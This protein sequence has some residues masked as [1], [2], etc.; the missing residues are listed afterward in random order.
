MVRRSCTAISAGKPGYRNQGRLGSPVIFFARKQT[1]LTRPTPDRLGS[2]CVF[3]GAGNGDRPFPACGRQEDHRN[4][5]SGTH[6]LDDTAR[7]P[8]REGA[9]STSAPSPGRAATCSTKACAACDLKITSTRRG[10]LI[11]VQFFGPSRSTGISATVKRLPAASNNATAPRPRTSRC[12]AA[13][14][15]N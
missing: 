1:R 7:S 11:E 8:E 3:A 14:T 2:G 12:N 10:A 6:S 4:A 5:S 9:N 13:F 15:A